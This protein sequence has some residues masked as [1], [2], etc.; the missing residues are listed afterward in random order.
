MPKKPTVLTPPIAAIFA[1]QK[2]CGKTHMATFL[3]DALVLNGC[4]FHAFQIDDQMRLSHM[5]GDTV[6]DLRPDPDLLVEDPTLTTRAIAPFY[7]ACSQAIAKK[8]SVILDTGANEVENLS[9]FLRDVD[10]AQDIDAWKLP[11]IAFV[12]FFPLDPESTA[13]SAFTARRLR[14]AVPNIRIVLVE[15]RFGGSVE[16]IVTGSIAATNYQGLLT[17][18]AGV[19][20]IV[21]PAIARE[22]WAPFEGA[23]MRFIKALALDPVDGAR[24][25]GRSVGEV[26]VMKSNVA[27]FWRSMHSQVARIIALPQG[28]N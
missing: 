4:P 26:K 7:D 6:T 1:A 13:Q 23:G 22:Y 3:A 19:E 24:Q 5:I 16:R 27:R 18:T 12:P 2:S 10:F 14:D 20:R 11:V 28:G 17:E 15:N 9:N 8:T 21:M 25:L